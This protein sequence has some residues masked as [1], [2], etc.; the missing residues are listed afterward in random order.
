MAKQPTPAWRS[1]LM[2]A[3][4]AL[5]FF[6]MYRLNPNA[7]KTRE[8]TQVEFFR[9]LDDGKIVEPVVRSL[10]HDEGE[11]FLTGEIETEELDGKGNPQRETYRVPLVPGENET[12]MD[13]L[14][15]RQTKVVIREKRS[16]F[17]PFITQLLF[18]FG[19]MLLFYWFFYRR[20][21]GGGGVLGFG[22]SRAKVLDGREEKRNRV[23]F[24]D[25]AG[26]DEAREE[27]QEI[28]E[29]L[30]D[31]A[32]F[33]KLGGRIP[34]GILLVGPPGTGKTLLAKAIAGEAK[35]PFF[36]MSGSDFEEMF[37]G[38][39]ASRM[40]DVFADA[41]KRA[42]C[43]VFID[44]ID[45]IGQKRTG[46]GAIGG[47][48]AY[49]QTLNT[50]LVEM[51]GFDANE[52]VIVIA[53][54]NRPDTLDAA[55]LR[56]GRFDRQVVVELPTL[57]GRREILELHGK[58]ITFA[59][60]ADLD[61]VARG[62]PGFSG[63]DLANLLNEAALLA[64]RKKLDGVDM[65]TLDEA[66]DKV[67]WGRERKSAGYSQKDR[68]I[69]AWHEAGHALLQVLLPDTDPLHKVTI[70]P[71]GRALGATMALPE[72]DI[73]NRTRRHFL[74]SIRLC[75]GGR[76]AEELFTGDISTGAAQDIAQATSVA[77]EMICRY[78]MSEAFG[79]QAFMEPSRFSDATLPPAFSEETARAIDA[80][81]KKLIDEAYADARRIISANRDRLERL[82][83][84]LLE[85]ETMDGRDV[86]AL[87][88]G[89]PEEK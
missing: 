78:G 61:R 56:P 81:V 31:P 8:M 75:C 49:E 39:G 21:G 32:S 28:V 4:V 23:T 37:V 11:T 13:E 17:S 42:P 89:E 66:R 83:K 6:S 70:I 40:R 87:V 19:F 24:S 38:V 9:A 26:V 16:A 52:G 54:T 50:M 1:W 69:T 18:F 84:A 20:M 5:V 57:K 22:K 85:Q 68:E 59:A 35:V 7:P 27:V 12:L 2:I 51:D 25:V 65:R 86:E 3:L 15:E 48:H 77:R 44:E 73:L 80:E 30:K 82:A 79:F 88:R 76:I 47:N 29:F 62:T 36:A 67:L 53:A 63:A 10:D 71:R 43:I 60:D 41:K 74:S 72:R 34:K 58:R 33:Q 46:A 14:F 45:S 64:V 55:L